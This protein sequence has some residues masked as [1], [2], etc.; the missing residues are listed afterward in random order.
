MAKDWE[1]RMEMQTSEKRGWDEERVSRVAC[2]GDDD[3]EESGRDERDE[4]DNEGKRKRR[5]SGHIRS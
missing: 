3:G 5:K 1:A 4:E 2:D